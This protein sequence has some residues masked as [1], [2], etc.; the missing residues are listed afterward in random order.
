MELLASQTLYYGQ[1]ILAYRMDLREPSERW[2][3]PHSK[4]PPP[5]YIIDPANPFNNLYLSGIG[6]DQ[7]KGEKKQLSEIMKE[8]QKMWEIFKEKIA[9]IDITNTEWNLEEEIN[10]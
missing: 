10:S 7:A 4:L 3:I 1:F 2:I 8:K 9:D 6:S 5:P